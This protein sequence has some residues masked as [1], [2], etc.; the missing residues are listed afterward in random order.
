MLE[1]RG[2]RSAKHSVP[3]L[4][5]R[6]GLAVLHHNSPVR[7]SAR[8][9]PRLVI[10]LA[11]QRSLSRGATVTC[12]RASPG[13]CRPWRLVLPTR[14]V[15]LQ[16]PRSAT[17]NTLLCANYTLRALPPTSSL[18]DIAEAA[19]GPGVTGARAVGDPT[20]TSIPSCRRR[21]GPFLPSII[22]QLLPF[23]DLGREREARYSPPNV[24]LGRGAL[25]AVKPADPDPESGLTLFCREHPLFHRCAPPILRKWVK[26]CKRQEFRSA[27]P[28][29]RRGQTQ[30]CAAEVR[31]RTRDAPQVDRPF[32]HP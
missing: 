8:A 24:K 29:S 30:S 16:R 5:A 26:D 21:C 9:L 20:A 12:A 11:E 3:G 32:L 22:Q 19:P 13:G 28:R 14:R 17:D 18:D 1:P 4:H 25:R 23:P 15:L 2:R 31:M 6:N 27:A 10:S 7:C